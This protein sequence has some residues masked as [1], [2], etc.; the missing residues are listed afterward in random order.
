MCVCVCVVVVVV[1]G[2]WWW[3]VVVVVG[4]WVGGWWGGVGLGMA[5]FISCHIVAC[6]YTALPPY[7][8]SSPSG[9]A[10]QE[11]APALF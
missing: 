5:D 3:L 8:P 4:G 10:K 11:V 7:S 9:Q 1:V 2:W 6:W